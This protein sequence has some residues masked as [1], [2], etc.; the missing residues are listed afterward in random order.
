MGIFLDLS[1][2]F[3]TVNYDILLQ[4]L[5]H[6]GFA[7]ITHTWFQNY[8]YDRQQFVIV[9]GKASDSAT[10]TCGVPQGSI[11]GPLL[12]LIYINDLAAALSSLFP[13]LFADDTNLFISHTDGKS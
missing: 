10:L 2:A 3:D 1:K 4:K 9:N 6:Y 8:I 12:F 13:V 11:L 7:G 5:L